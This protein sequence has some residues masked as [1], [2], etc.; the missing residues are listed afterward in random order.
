MASTH[1]NA[2]RKASSPN[3]GDRGIG[4]EPRSP[5][6][7]GLALT[8][9]GV[10]LLGILASLL[11]LGP[12]QSP[13]SD[14]LLQAGSRWQGRFLFREPIKRYE[15][16]VEVVVTERTGSR[17]KGEYATEGGNWRWA[18]AG[19]IEQQQVRW[20]FTGIIKETEPR[21]IVGKAQVDGTCRGEEMKVELSIPNTVYVA[22][23]TL[24]LEK[25]SPR[26]TK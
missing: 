8:G 10:V 19:V 14:D 1:P 24:R 21:D 20:Q 17:F 11:F 6:S 26:V 2:S 25:Q 15:G 16:D 3:K 13:A 23:M 22:D 4:G 5:R 12:W 9:A 18:I 7:K